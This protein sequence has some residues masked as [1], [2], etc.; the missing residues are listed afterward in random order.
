MHF[1]VTAYDGKDS[2][3]P[4]RRSNAR[5]RH[6]AGVKELIKEG[7]H[8]YAAAI[9]DDDG[10]MAGSV[11]I[12]DYP[13]KEALMAEWLGREPYVTGNVWEEIDIR[14]CRVPDFFLDTSWIQ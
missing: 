6:L 1:L 8:L 7:R 12:V 3:A 11:L 10:R 4:A 13:S 14:P 2:E 5:E 9:L